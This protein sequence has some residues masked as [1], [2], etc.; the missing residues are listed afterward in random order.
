MRENDKYQFDFTTIH[1]KSRHG[2]EE[3]ADTFDHVVGGLPKYKAAGQI[4]DRYEHWQAVPS[5]LLRQFCHQALND[6][7]PAEVSK[8]WRGGLLHAGDKQKLD[9]QGRPR[10]RPLVVGMAIRRI[11]GRLPCAQ[12]K[13]EFASKFI[14]LRQLG[15]AATQACRHM[16]SAH[17]I[18]AIPQDRKS[19]LPNHAVHSAHGSDPRGRQAGTVQMWIWQQDIT[20][21]R[22]ALHLSMQICS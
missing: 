11:A 21:I 18:N 1:I 3:E 14:K 16:G 5:K 9:S 19:C 2:G 12:L 13:D 17:P 4:G 15:V 20:G 8:I 7:I 6:E 10:V 22:Y